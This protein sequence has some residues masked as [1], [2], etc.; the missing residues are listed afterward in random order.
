MASHFEPAPHQVHFWAVDQQTGDDQVSTVSAYARIQGASSDLK[1]LHAHLL[2]VWDLHQGLRSRLEVPE[3]FS[4][5]LLAVDESAAPCIVS[6]SLEAVDS[7][8]WLRGFHEQVGEAERN[9]ANQHWLQ[10]G[11]VLA[12]AP[13]GLIHVS[14]H[15]RAE[16]VDTASLVMIL[17]DVARR[18]DALPEVHR[19]PF[20]DVA[21]WLLTSMPS[22]ETS[23]PT[24]VGQR[25]A[26]C[27]MQL[28]VAREP[29]VSLFP[30]ACVEAVL[31]AAW[32]SLVARMNTVHAISVEVCSDVRTVVGDS[33]GV[34]PYSM[35]RVQCVSVEEQVSFQDVVRQVHL[36]ICEP[37][38]VT[39]FMLPAQA[40]NYS[41]LYTRIEKR[42]EIGRVSIEVG[43]LQYSASGV[44]LVLSC[45]DSGTSLQVNISADPSL[46]DVQLLEHIVQGY[47]AILATILQQPDA[48][49]LQMPLTA[50]PKQ[51]AAQMQVSG[52][53]STQYLPF[54]L[55]LQRTLGWASERI[56]LRCG[57]QAWSYKTLDAVASGMRVQ[58]EAAGGRRGDVI[59]LMMP[60]SPELIAAMVAVMRMGG[61]F[62]PLDISAPARRL[63]YVLD[64]AEAALVMVDPTR[65]EHPAL[66]NRRCVLVQ[67]EALPVDPAAQDEPVLLEPDD[68]A[69]VLYTSGSTGQPKGVELTHGGLSNYLQY[70]AHAYELD[71]GRGAVVQSPVTFDLTLTALLGPLLVGQTVIL[72]EDDAVNGAGAQIETVRDELIAGNLTLLKATP[73]YLQL[74]NEILPEKHFK[75]AVHS[76]VVGGEMLHWDVIAP[77]LADGVTTRIF[78]EY[79]PTETVVGSICHEATR[80]DV[81]MGHVPIGMPVDYT[82]ILV[83]D[84][85]GNPVPSD[86]FGEICIGGRGVGRGY[87]NLPELTQRSFVTLPWFD[88]PQRFY[89]TGDLGRVRAS[90]EIELVGRIDAQ[91]KVNGVRIEPGEIEALLLAHCRISAA[92]VMKISEGA[93]ETLK[94]Y[95]VPGNSDLPDLLG[96]QACLMEHLP[97]AM[98]PG[99][100]VA[101]AGFPLTRH[102]KLDREA[103]L[104]MA[105]IDSLKVGAV[106]SKTRPVTPLESL[107]VDVWCRTLGLTDVGT[108]EDFFSLGGDSIRSIALVGEARLQGVEI[109]VAEV[110]A[111]RTIQALAQACQAQKVSPEQPVERFALLDEQDMRRLPQGLEDAYP[112][113]TLQLA[114]VYH[115]EHGGSDALYHDIFSYH[116]R[117]A[118]DVA[119]LTLAARQLV[120][121]YE[122]LRTT[123]DLVS[124]SQ[125]LQLVHPHG[126]DMLI[127]EDISQLSLEQQS[128]VV[129]RYM[130]EEKSRRFDIEALPM[131]RL[132]L[133]IRG[134]GTVQLTMSFHHALIDGWSDVVILTELF[135]LYFALLA[136]TLPTPA[137]KA[138]YAEFVKL[139][140][141]TIADP[142]AREFWRKELEGYRFVPLPRAV[143][144]KQGV[145][146]HPIS[147]PTPVAERLKQIAQDNDLPLKSLLFA[148]HLKVMALLR[149]QDDC[150]SSIVVNG[151]PETLDG[152]RMVGLFINS[153][154]VRIQLEDES[155]IDLARRVVSRERD[156]LVYRRLPFAE[157]KTLAGGDAISETLFYFTNYYIARKLKQEHGVELL[158]LSGHEA[159]SFKLVANFWVEPFTEE[160]KASLAVDRSVVD[161]TLLMKLSEC[162]ERALS[163]IAETPYAHHSDLKLR[164]SSDVQAHADFTVDRAFVSRATLSPGSDA[165][166]H[167][168]THV[169]FA[170]LAQRV[171]ACAQRL[172]SQGV[173]PGD[174][175]GLCATMT[176]AF[177]IAMLATMRCG[178]V[179]V[180]L[181]TNQPPARLRLILE[182]SQP[183]LVLTD[184]RGRTLLPEATPCADL[185]EMTQV[186]ADLAALDVSLSKAEGLAYLS[187]TSGSTGKPKGV[188]VSQASLSSF[189]AAM[190]DLLSSDS[191]SVWLSGTSVGFDISLLELLFPLTEGHTVVLHDD[192]QALLP[193]V[194]SGRKNPRSGPDMSLFFF[195]SEAPDDAY[196]LLLESARR[197]DA[198]GFNAIWTP[199]RHFNAF[200]GPFPNPSITSAALAMVTQRLQIR[201]GSLVMPLHDPVRVAEDWAMVDQLSSGRVGLSIGSG[202]HPDDF[203]LAREPHAQRRQ[204][205]EEGI[206]VLTRLWRGEAVSVRDSDGSTRSVST[207]P[208]PVQAQLPIWLSAAGGRETFELAGYSGFGV[209]THLLAQDVEGLTENIA[210]YRRASRE[211][212]HVALMLHSYVG[213]SAQQALDVA[214]GP[215]RQYLDG[216]MNLASP[217][218]R[219]EGDSRARDALLEQAVQRYLESASL[220]GS[221][222]ECVE[223]ARDLHRR[224]VDELACL[225]D[226]GIDA[227]QV[228][229]NLERLDEVRARAGEIASVSDDHSLAALIERHGVTH[230]QCTP[231]LL[232]ELM[233]NPRTGRALRSLDVL[234][235]GGEVLPETLAQRLR[236]EGPSRVLHMYGPTE[237]TIW[238][239]GSELSDAVLTLG[240]PL[241]NSSLHVLDDEGQ[242]VRDEEPGEIHIAGACLANG[243]WNNAPLTATAFVDGLVPNQGRL[244]RT[245]DIGM[246]LAD[247]K[248]K[249][250]GRKDR[251]LKIMGQRIEP[252]EIEHV[253]MTHPAVADC[254]VVLEADQLVAAI[255]PATGQVLSE[256][257][258]RHFALDHLPLGMVPVRFL[259]MPR[260]PRTPNGKLDASGILSLVG[261]SSASTVPV[262]EPAPETALSTRISQLWA[263]TLGAAPASADA[264]FFRSGGNSLKAMLFA[265]HLSEALSVDVTVRTV[266]ENATVE[267]LTRWISQQAPV[268]LEA[269]TATVEQPHSVHP[270][271]FSQS[272]LWA[273][274]QL[275]PQSMA[276]NDA[277]L[278]EACGS[279]SIERV[280]AAV[281][282]VIARHECLRS[283]FFEEHGVGRVRYV[284]SC[285][286]DFETVDLRELDQS[287]RIDAGIALAREVA[288]KGFDLEQ[289]PLLRM[290]VTRLGEE[291]YQLLL[292]V[293]HIVSDG[294]SLALFM[295]EIAA[296]YAEPERALPPLALT[297][298]EFVR[299]Q[300]DHLAPALKSEQLRYWREQLADLPVPFELPLD[301]SRSHALDNQGAITS[302]FIVQPLLKALDELAVQQGTSTHILLVSALAVVLMRMSGRT[303]IVVGSDS[304]NRLSPDTQELGGLL[305]NQLAIRCDLSAD[306]SFAQLLARVHGTALD[307]YDHQD[308]PFQMIVNDLS[309]QREVF[310]NPIFQV[311]FTL[312]ET[313][314]FTVDSLSQ[315]TLK[316]LPFDIGIARLDLEFNAHRTSQGLTLQAIY[317][318]QL[319]KVETV[320]RLLDCLLRLLQGVLLEPGRPI[321]QIDIIGDAEKD[322]LLNQFN[323]TAVAW[324]QR[325]FLEIF[326]DW[327]TRTPDA[328]AV[329]GES[330]ALSYLELDEQARLLALRLRTEGVQ[331]GDVVA[332][333]CHRDVPLLVSMLALWR[334]SAVYLPL[335]PNW[336][337][338]R[339]GELLLESSVRH[340]LCT[341]DLTPSVGDACLVARQ[342]GQEVGIIDLPVRLVVPLAGGEDIKPN[343]DVAD[344]AAYVMFTSGSTGR[345]KGAIV[346]HCGMMNHLWAKISDL[347]LQAG[348]CVAQ[349]APQTFDICVWQMLSALVVGG[350]VRI[351]DDEMAQNPRALI[352][353]I[354]HE[355]VTVLQVVPSFLDLAITAASAAGASTLFAKLRW[356]IST[357]EPLTVALCRRW[358]VVFPNIP[359]MNAYGPA[360]CSDDVTHHV[361]THMPE[362]DAVSIPIGRPVGNVRIYLVDEHLNIVPMGAAGELCVTGIAVGAGYLNNPQAT[363]R[364][365][366]EDPFNAGSPYGLYRTGDLARWRPDGVLEFL[367]RV[368]NQVK[369]RGCRIELGEVEAVLNEDALVRQSVVIAAGETHTRLVGYVAADWP[370]VEAFIADHANHDRTAEWQSIYEFYYQDGDERAVEPAHPQAPIDPTF[371]TRGW[372]DSFTSDAIPAQ[373]MRS[374]LDQTVERIQSLKPRRILE[375][376]CGTGMLL[377]RLAEGC[378]RYRGIDLSAV[379]ISQLQV[380]LAERHPDWDHVEVSQCAAHELELIDE[381]G[382]DCII[383]NSVVQYFPGE[384]YLRNVLEAASRK[385]VKGGHIFLG[386]IRALEMLE[387]F[388]QAVQLTGSEDELSLAELAERTRVA[389]TRDKELLLSNRF[390]NGLLAESG[391]DGRPVGVRKWLKRGP[392]DNELVRYRLDIVLML[393]TRASNVIDSVTWQDVAGSGIV[394]RLRD[395]RVET[396]LITG[397]P[398]LRLEAECRAASC[399]AANESLRTV[400]EL[401]E[402]MRLLAMPTRVCPDELI[403]ELAVQGYVVQTGFSSVSQ[404]AF[405]FDLLVSR[406]EISWPVVEDIDTGAIALSSNPLRNRA[407]QVLLQRL[408]EKLAERLPSYMVPGTLVVLDD[409]PL[410]RNGK[411]NRRALP[412]VQLVQ[413]ETPLDEPRTQAERI[414]CQIW[415][416]LL[417]VKRVG[418]RANFFALGGDS[419]LAIQMVSMAAKQ[420]LKLKTRQVFRHQTIGDLAAATIGQFSEDNRDEPLHGDFALAPNQ[421]DF[422]V[423]GHANI[424]HWNQAVVLHCSEALNEPLLRD[425]LRH[426]LHRNDA[427]RM[428]FVN[429]HGRWHQVYSPVAECPDIPLTLIAHDNTEA[430][431]AAE[432]Q[433]NAGLSLEHGPI[434]RVAVQPAGDGGTCKILLVAH[435]LVIDAVS[436]RIIVDQLSH[437][438]QAL[439]AQ[440][441]PMLPSKGA[442]Y[443]EWVERHIALA[444]SQVLRDQWPF[445]VEQ[446]RVGQAHPIAGS[447]GGEPAGTAII[448][449]MIDSHSAHRLTQPAPRLAGAS[450]EEV[451][452]TALILGL[453]QRFGNND[454]IVLM[455]GHGRDL[456]D[457]LDLSQTVGWFATEYPMRLRVNE[458]AN[459]DRQIEGLLEQ[460]RFAK[461]HQVG[462]GVL[463][464]FSPDASMRQALS[465]LPPAE[466]AFNYFGRVSRAGGVPGPLSFIEAGGGT[467]RDSMS[468][469]PCAVQLDV[470]VREQA[471]ELHWTLDLARISRERVLEVARAFESQLTKA[472]DI[473]E[474]RDDTTQERVSDRFDSV[475]IEDLGAAISE[476]SQ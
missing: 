160:V 164:D 425:A 404:A 133:H 426:L 216:A 237:A 194:S 470:L 465:E 202:W 52:P 283:R 167:R 185:I 297:Y 126:P 419:I 455:E 255:V 85:Q 104:A 263:R 116:L 153:I 390:F 324:E 289:G 210:S 254:A 45:V 373:Q 379:V 346:Q 110:F 206:D 340:V 14:L 308:L 433:L 42:I 472:L 175:V 18:I 143:A 451:L 464:H 375:I 359:L 199:E 370:Q 304:A 427:L 180:P 41:F 118:P 314:D 322:R 82:H 92:A 103:L 172:R 413:E 333:I 448:T 86:V 319:Y 36:D 385:L 184:L 39:T 115:N 201:A 90:G 316:P 377:F 239:S 30:D 203:V 258:L 26:R 354:D 272:S 200:G 71:K 19:I 8:E 101:V 266:F 32:A 462:F 56:A 165:L 171:Q 245:G 300:Q 157:I 296:K 410:L 424:N 181:A 436:W 339:I 120:Q 284:Q 159:S 243:Y 144:V 113:A 366:L 176:P 10:G 295:R 123:F 125:P 136:D 100:I 98:V 74:I 51:L 467:V 20:A 287:Q 78:N 290:L 234:L 182:D 250:L 334:V 264:H 230:F 105:H 23:V 381:T 351:Y 1:Q 357:G 209:L 43:E 233:A 80:D 73:S 213:T 152:D 227:N 278:V 4:E 298:S 127:V 416:E 149:Q 306:P 3:G 326:A 29:L 57:G 435:H 221:V 253:L 76:L 374:W 323:Q 406:Q 378:E 275:A 53:A 148:V 21:G 343:E 111:N 453:K 401:R 405:G 22:G 388:H 439:A 397:V 446:A 449:T 362:V 276:Y 335:D 270:L 391:L 232:R 445:W 328:Q 162:Y 461:R 109:T 450:V 102:G 268:T 469:N 17:E 40:C 46:Y 305:V 292:V 364:Q 368:D 222:E 137:P 393:D 265:K 299:R 383:L 267:A 124:Y 93:S 218:T 338:R 403:H 223:R 294:W 430:F 44:P 198:M 459:V 48:I 190:S 146:V 442:S 9:T 24:R 414:L 244:Y 466:I 183:S 147:L 396:L 252:G 63:G 262:I 50:D 291:H 235:V 96:M 33:A 420:G 313:F 474:G 428:R 286:F 187:Y 432:A 349:T 246:R 380:S 49:A 168:N 281:E 412:K 225:I 188:A 309:P 454:V 344:A 62:L 219:R 72:I 288:R 217:A 12:V 457:E 35:P 348:D 331:S 386:D 458:H 447:P 155:W 156:L 256:D 2:T 195:A 132:M 347:S 64:N 7:E 220:I 177:V 138:R 150:A 241:S 282:C 363:Q 13:D 54:P 142:V 372:V 355:A 191:A 88:T 269:R 251:Q 352:D 361:I 189:C 15:H 249:F 81:R 332:V 473:L 398:N 371:D 70:A 417:G 471:V 31:L 337:S 238:V 231:T 423:A 224:G 279:L 77:W 75:G 158:K 178:A 95:V 402:Q 408:R 387:P 437:L 242:P 211:K 341:D 174:R 277:M 135:E 68:L 247:G 179:Y 145:H 114:M 186:S 384:S 360:E 441:S 415:G 367:G 55:L 395:S 99:Q 69:Y 192:T 107:L 5:P 91:M 129:E 342:A 260:L 421:M 365:F 38:D 236:R 317:N 468:V 108:D 329:V 193:S 97:A 312:Q 205:M 293:H 444:E 311:A 140:Q 409:F 257:A 212:T 353:A 392:F 170:E 28:K 248:I 151:R 121:N 87:R 173:M 394:Q 303:D 310:R 65:H 139:E 376:G 226:F 301:Y 422:F 166:I 325:S 119:L 399:L 204:S 11:A 215:L 66:A 240:Q 302:L 112:M 350:R 228:L 131:M 321:S 358:F 34:G 169:S 307:A 476:I 411:V 271:S 163:S 16:V 259:V 61:V 382:F 229:E 134:D 197:A 452:L 128:A 261:T 418:I 208:R 6:L 161:E 106:E 207:L 330:G 59:A 67:D 122:V 84:S 407:Q 327:V 89:R 60:R 37:V 274:V 400:G 463:K 214:G 47:S 434:M 315:L 117:F 27:S 345:P 336:P 25:P 369:I 320:D 79:G 285:A 475:A 440:R 154:P 196:R 356:L 438:L 429:E 460:I 389:I 83:L 280:R 130:A 94:A 318:N 443:R 273:M 58:L 141:A 431:Q 456:F